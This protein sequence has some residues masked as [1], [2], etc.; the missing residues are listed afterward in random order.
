MACAA[1]AAPAADVRASRMKPGVAVARAA[2]ARSWAPSFEASRRAPS[3]TTSERGSLSSIGV[4]RDRAAF[5]RFCGL[6]PRAFF[7]ASPETASSSGSSLTTA[8]ARHHA[9]LEGS[10]APNSAVALGDSKDTD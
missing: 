10:C 1:P 8:A 7:T 3:A 4:A 9:M 6:G 2:F 5:A